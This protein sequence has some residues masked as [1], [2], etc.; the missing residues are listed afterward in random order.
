MH[1]SRMISS[2]FMIFSAQ[3]VAVRDSYTFINSML[4]VRVSVRVGPFRGDTY[5]NLFCH[6]SSLCSI[7]NQC[8][9]FCRM[10]Q[11]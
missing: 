3:K 2:L 7:N 6:L 9:Y 11:L 1:M 8:K 10:M 5:L 4:G